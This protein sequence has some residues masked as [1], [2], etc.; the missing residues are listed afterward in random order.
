MVS[1]S[2]VVLLGVAGALA[3]QVPLEAT[4]NCLTSTDPNACCSSAGQVEGKETASQVVFHYKCRSY[5]SPTEPKG[6]SAVNAHECASLCANDDTCHAAAWQTNGLVLEAKQHLDKIS[7]LQSSVDNNKKMLQ[8]E[9]DAIIK[10]AKPC[11]TMNPPLKQDDGCAMTVGGKKWLFLYGKAIGTWDGQ[12][13]TPG[14]HALTCK[15]QLLLFAMLPKRMMSDLTSTG[16]T[17]A[18]VAKAAQR[19]VFLGTFKEWKDHS[20]SLYLHESDSGSFDIFK[21]TELRLFS[22]SL[23]MLE[24]TILMAEENSVLLDEF[25]ISRAL[26]DVE[27]TSIMSR[28]NELFS[29]AIDMNRKQHVLQDRRLAL[30]RIARESEAYEIGTQYHRNVIGELLSEISRLRN[31]QPVY[32][33]EEDQLPIDAINAMTGDYQCLQRDEAY[34]GGESPIPILWRT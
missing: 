5:P 28:E 19:S 16:A 30:K 10:W 32:T 7:E 14:T 8:Q 27:W 4:R 11:R 21:E 20:S 24:H 23:Q 31:G 1:K 9:Y 17:T 26:S 12:Q 15:Q 6:K 13:Q 33:E 3:Q 18:Q 22:E 25:S 29:A 2:I 34:H